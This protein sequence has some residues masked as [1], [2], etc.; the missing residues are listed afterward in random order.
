[1]PESSSVSSS[2]SAPS[3][4]SS[5]PDYLLSIRSHVK[6]LMHCLKYPYAT[7]TGILLTPSSTM[8]TS[9]T[10]SNSTGGSSV[11]TSVEDNNGSSCP[12]VTTSSTNSSVIS[13]S[14][15][16]G[17]V[18]FVDVV[19]LF[20]LGHGLTPMLEV[21]LLQVSAY[22]R[23]RNLMIG[24]LY[25]ASRYFHD[26]GPDVFA[27]RTVD[28]IWEQ[29]NSA[30]LLSV[31]NFGLASAVLND[32]ERGE[33]SFHVFNYLDGKWKQQQRSRV[34]RLEDPSKSFAA[35]NELILS[36]GLQEQLKDFDNHLDDVSNDWRNQGVNEK[37]AKF[38]A[39][40]STTGVEETQ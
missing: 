21:A 2:F 10:G 29:N 11:N 7:V 25:H 38:V 30:I 24:G 17:G 1:M 16:E 8:T 5:P 19:P 15:T 33:N 27:F 9:P 23:D 31:N 20:H 6:I 26:S 39:S 28:K 34:L 4:L 3:S 22:C 35:I 14:G 37:I 18:E 40:T 36:Q 12:V 13:K 32:G